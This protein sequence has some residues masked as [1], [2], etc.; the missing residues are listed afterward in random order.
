MKDGQPT[1]KLVI[2]DVVKET[3]TNISGKTSSRDLELPHK[4][5]KP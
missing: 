1:G 5:K 3:K 4:P 2:K